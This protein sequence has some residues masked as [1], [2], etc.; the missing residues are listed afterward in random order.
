M[1]QLTAEQLRELLGPRRDSPAPAVTPAAPTVDAPP[2]GE[3]RGVI[4]WLIPTALRVV[5]SVAGGVLG[6]AG[7][8]A[9]IVAGG[10]AGAGLGEAAAQWY[11]GD[12]RPGSIALQTALGAIPLTRGAGGVASRALRGAAQGGLLSGASVTGES[13]IR[14]GELPSAGALALGVGLGGALGGATAAITPSQAR[15]RRA[16]T[17]IARITPDAPPPVDTPGIPGRVPR[18]AAQAVDTPEIPGRVPSVAAQVDEAVARPAQS[19]MAIPTP[20]SQAARGAS[21]LTAEGV[22]KASEREA[23]EPIKRQFREFAPEYADDLMNTFE[24][25]IVRYDSSDTPVGRGRMSWQQID[26]L[27]QRVSADIG[28]G[29]PAGTTLNAEGVTRL[30]RTVVGIENRIKSVAAELAEARTAPA[31]D[32]NQQRIVD[33]SKQ[34]LELRA[35]REVVG[36]SWLGVRAETGRAL[37]VLGQLRRAF[38]IQDTAEG[39]RINAEM[40][41]R[42][43]EFSDLVNR[44]GDDTLGLYR[45]LQREARPTF[46]QQVQSYWYANILSGLKTHE[47]NILGNAANTLYNFATQPVAVGL[48]AAQSTLTGRE[49]SIFLSDLPREAVGMW[50]G[51]QAG[52]R[53]AMFTLRKGVSPRQLDVLRGKASKAYTLADLDIP[54]QELPGGSL[55]PLNYVSRGLEAMDN[56]FAS[57]A[58]HQELYGG[59][60]AAA[61]RELKAGRITRAQFSDRMAEILAEGGD[62]ADAAQRYARRATFREEPGSLVKGVEALKRKAPILNYVIP[63]VRTPAAIFRQG[64]EATPLGVFTAQFREELAAGGR[65]AAQA[66]ARM[67]LGTLVTGAMGYLAAQGRISGAGPSNYLERQALMDSGWR[68]NSIKIGDRWVS[69]QLFQPLSLPMSVMGNMADSI[70]SR[71]PDET[72]VDTLMAAVFSSMRSGL[73]QS[74][75]SGVQGLLDAIDEPERSA[76]RFAGNTISGFIPG[77]SMLR[78]VAQA[79]DPTVRMTPTVRER[80]QAG[81]PGMSQNLAPMINRFGEEVQRFEGPAAPL[82]ALA[83]PFSVS[84]ESQDPVSQELARLRINIARPSGTLTLRGEE[85]ELPQDLAVQ[86]QQ[87]RGQGVYQ[88]LA[89][90]VSAPGYARLSDEQ[91]EA[92]LRRTIRQGRERGV[93]RASRNV[94]TE[95]RQR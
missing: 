6:A 62:L 39:L 43:Q 17:E 35:E 94:I 32:A 38:G 5:P 49:R 4:D 48:D 58:Y 15:P 93:E 57:I 9:G 72:E 31:S 71:G 13:L 12:I 89:R 92:L 25:I 59:A 55:N 28:E 1:A 74:F 50:T 18:V 78:S 86:M 91:K 22:L 75:F 52:F 40:V 20:E 65:R 24:D 63:F 46:G 16:A 51:L 23:L 95:L 21:R 81:I 37:A 88:A 3:G 83:D 80:V 27:S 61:T 47:R 90:V 73:D 29:L 87:A 26:E 36:K 67:A 14:E 70:R 66:K 2:E 56:F 42:A 34:L 79:T 64:V 53:D 41:Q 77:S 76:S 33:L 84:R 85:L 45:E 44:Y 19:P 69:Y 30:T 7:G 11:E 60:H 8:P 68:P 54:R 82:Q 10:A